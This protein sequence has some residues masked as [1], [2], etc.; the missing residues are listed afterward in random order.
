VTWIG[1]KICYFAA[2]GRQRG[3][4]RRRTCF[5]HGEKSTVFSRPRSH[6]AFRRALFRQ[7]RDFGYGDRPAKIAA[8]SLLLS[9]ERDSSGQRPR[10]EIGL[11]AQNSEAVTALV[12]Q[13]QVV[14]RRSMSLLLAHRVISPQCNVASEW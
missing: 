1:F 7:E 2:W 5:P 8:T 6:L 4:R 9:Q 3:L 13:A 10:A 14:S 11:F 12:G